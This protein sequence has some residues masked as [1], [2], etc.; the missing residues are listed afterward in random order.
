MNKE[1]RITINIAGRNYPLLVKTDELEVIREIEK[2]LK[3]KYLE[4]TKAFPALE[5][6]DHLAM[7]LLEAVKKR[8]NG[9]NETQ[10]SLVDSELNTIILSLH[11]HLH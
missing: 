2:N 3:Q 1:E 5:I 9:T 10:D 8:T 7:M 6:R 4:V 11:N